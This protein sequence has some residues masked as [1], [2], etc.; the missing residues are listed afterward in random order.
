MIIFQRLLPYLLLLITVFFP[1]VKVQAQFPPSRDSFPGQ[2]FSP[3]RII[4]FE[5]RGMPKLYRI[6]EHQN[7]Q[8]SFKDDTNSSLRIFTSI[9]G[10]SVYL[11]GKGYRFREVKSV[12]LTFDHFKPVVY[13]QTDSASWKLYFPPDSVYRSRITYSKYM[14]WIL[15]VRK[16]DKF[17]WLAPPFRQNIIKLNISRFA[18]LEIALSYEFRFSK[19]WSWEVETGYQFCAGHNLDE[20]QPMGLY[21][22]F[23]YSG[24]SLITGPK[25][26]FNE[27]GYIQAMM[28]YRYLEMDS[29]RSAFESTYT[30]LQDEFRNDY[31]ISIRIGKLTRMGGV[32]I[33]GYAGIGIKAM[34]IRQYAYGR[35]DS[36]DRRM[37]YWF[38]KDHSPKVEDL[39]TLAPIIG[40]G[41]KLGFGF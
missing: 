15:H 33:D 38:N 29:A 4:F 17:L 3:K 25:Y 40:L 10:D 35:Y 31:G 30:L 39:V 26:Y 9:H 28:H 34:M 1:G 41:I 19:E 12:F 11:D 16:H 20:D 22:I 2:R 27:R 7:R 36:D 32:L 14:H 18:N 8:V 21:P 24:M 23:K 5:T 37:F 13:R 6:A